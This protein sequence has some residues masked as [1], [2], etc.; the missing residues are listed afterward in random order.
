MGRIFSY[1]YLQRAIFFILT[2]V[3]GM[4]IMTSSR[5]STEAEM[6][7]TQGMN[8]YPLDNLDQYHIAMKTYFK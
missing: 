7:K 5:I 3:G 4:R 6:V 2:W 8:Q 1:R